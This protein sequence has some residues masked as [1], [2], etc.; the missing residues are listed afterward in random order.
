MSAHNWFK[1]RRRHSRTWWRRNVRNTSLLVQW[2]IFLITS[3]WQ[4][5]GP[6]V[7]KLSD[8]LKGISSRILCRML[9]AFSNFQWL[10]TQFFWGKLTSR[11]PTLQSIFVAEAPT[12]QQSYRTSLT[13]YAIPTWTHAPPRCFPLDH[14]WEVCH[15]DCLSLPREFHCWLN[16]SARLNVRLDVSYPIS[17]PI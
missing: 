14:Q 10:A 8:Q 1:Y 3:M 7:L 12:D 17:H 11:T 6:W 15:A 2:A 9:W 13:A 5:S 16:Q 4:C